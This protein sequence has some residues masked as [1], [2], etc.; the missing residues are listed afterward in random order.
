MSD[1]T[2]DAVNT[3]ESALQ[4][5]S[6]STFDLAELSAVAPGLPVAMEASPDER[7]KSRAQLGRQAVT[8][9]PANSE[10]EHQRDSADK[11]EWQ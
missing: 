4:P 10:C 5:F 3:T 1:A 7:S 8:V 2:S 6:E 9:E 11:L